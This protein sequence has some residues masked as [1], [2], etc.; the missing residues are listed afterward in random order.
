MIQ[1]HPRAI[2]QRSS[3]H[4]ICLVQRLQISNS[5]MIHRGQSKCRN[6]NKNYRLLWLFRRL[7]VIRK[8]TK[9]KFQSWKVCLKTKRFSRNAPNA[10]IMSLS[11]CR[12]TI[13]RW[14]TWGS[15]WKYRMI[16][17]W[18]SRPVTKR[19]PKHKLIIGLKWRAS[20]RLIPGQSHG[21]PLKLWLMPRRLLTNTRVS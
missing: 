2:A 14:M 6:R 5:F 9:T 3:A 19:W 13:W 18:S 11:T 10:W 15:F 16:A 17:N 21:R 1:D 20:I 12:S 4:K 8:W 7:L